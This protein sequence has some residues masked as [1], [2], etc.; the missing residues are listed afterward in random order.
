M[1]YIQV[2]GTTFLR[3]IPGSGNFLFDF[4]H[5]QPV[6]TLTAEERAALG[7]VTCDL[8]APPVYDARKQRL[9]EADAE[10]IGDTWHQVWA[11]VNKSSEEIAAWDRSPNVLAAAR[12]GYEG[13]VKRR[14]SRLEKPGREQDRTGALALRVGLLLK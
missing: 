10:L 13:L 4:N 14:A 8:T 9:E 12:S 7:I 11:V 5:F 6:G 3:H 1:K 2:S